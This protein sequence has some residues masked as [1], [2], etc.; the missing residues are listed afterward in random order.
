M[1]KI[2]MMVLLILFSSNIFSTES[3]KVFKCAALCLSLNPQTLEVHLS[4]ELK[5]TSYESRERAIDLI[6]R[7]CD[8]LDL[9]SHKILGVSIS[10]EKL[11]EKDLCF[12]SDNEN[13]LTK[14]Y[15]TPASITNA[16]E[17]IESRDVPE[18]DGK[19]PFKG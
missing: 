6:K 11:T 15:I 7:N 19:L 12:Y 3:Y 13:I 2:G 17:E 5:V 8:L 18:Y 4:K 16:C 9:R 14:M 1:K 10:L